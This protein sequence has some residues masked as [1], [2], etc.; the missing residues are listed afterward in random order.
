MMCPCEKEEEEEK[1]K[2]KRMEKDNTHFTYYYQSKT[3]LHIYLSD[4]NVKYLRK[5][6]ESY[7]LSLSLFVLSSSTHSLHFHTQQHTDT[8]NFPPI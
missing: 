2:G 5:E 6:F 3:G 7:V 1:K 8:R 4:L